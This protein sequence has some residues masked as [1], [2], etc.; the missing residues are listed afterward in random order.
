MRYQA[1]I[2]VVAAVTKPEALSAISQVVGRPVQG[3]AAHLAQL[4]LI[5]V[6]VAALLFGGDLPL[7]PSP[8]IP[9]HAF[10]LWVGLA[11]FFYAVLELFVVVTTLLQMGVMIIAEEQRA[12]PE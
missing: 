1:T 10:G 11:A 4:L 7:A 5:M 9:S 3:S 12:V 6:C 2:I 8:M